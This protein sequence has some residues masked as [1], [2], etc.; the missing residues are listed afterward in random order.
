MRL[1]GQW[2][3]CGSIAV[4]S[5]SDVSA[6]HQLVDSSSNVDN[7]IQTISNMCACL[8][9]NPLLSP[10]AIPFLIYPSSPNLL[11]WHRR[12]NPPHSP[13]LS[14]A[15]LTYR[16]CSSSLA[17]HYAPYPVSSSHQHLRSR[18]SPSPSLP[19]LSC[20]VEHSLPLSSLSRN[21][22]TPLLLGQLGLFGQTPGHI[23]SLSLSVKF[24]HFNSSDCASDLLAKIH[25]HTLF[26]LHQDHCA[27]LLRSLFR[28]IRPFPTKTTVSQ[29]TN[30]LSSP[31]CCI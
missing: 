24:G 28:G 2:A 14:Y 18:P 29:L 16:Q 8:G 31:L 17:V 21:S 1:S 23:G 15:T 11:P 27:D 6:S 3:R 20:L 10:H 25:P 7:L 13:N 30:S 9:A 19:S 22:S 5:S 26:S 4:W 12:S